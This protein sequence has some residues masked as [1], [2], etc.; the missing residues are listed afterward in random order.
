MPIWSDVRSALGGAVAQGAR[1][2][3]QRFEKAPAVSIAGI[4]GLRP[5][6]EPVQEERPAKVP[7]PRALFTDPFQISQAFGYRNRVSCL[8]YN[9]LRDLVYQ[10]PLVATIVSVRVEQVASFGHVAADKYQLGFR[11][12]MREKHDSPSS[13]EEEMCRKYEKFLLHTGLVRNDKRK[14]TFETYLR[15]IVRDALV[16]D[17]NCTELIPGNNGAPSEFYAIDASNVRLAS[18]LKDAQRPD[19]DGVAY[20]E[21]YNETIRTRWRED[22]IIFGVRN[23]NT[24][25]RLNGYGTSELEYVISSVTQMINAIKYNSAAFTNGTMARGI[26]NIRDEDLSNAQLNQIERNWNAMLK[27]VENAW[28]TPVIA[29]KNGVDWVNLQGAS[30]MQYREWLDWLVKCITASYKIA[31][32]ELNLSYGNIGQNST[33][34][35]ASNKDKI[36]DSKERGLRPL[37]RHISGNVNKHLLWP[38]APELEF[39]FCGLDAMTKE[40]QADFNNKR[41]S[42]YLTLNEIR[43]EED[44]EPL[45]GGDI[46][47]NGAYLQSLQQQ[48]MQAQ[49]AQTQ[50]VDFSDPAGG[51]EPQQDEQPQDGSQAPAPMGINDLLSMTK[52][53]SAKK[54]SSTGLDIR[55]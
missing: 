5:I 27:G 19:N 47:L 49:Q 48:Q 28:R 31:P 38:H 2:V 16:F 20:V 30:D 11:V 39:E 26:L 1:R 12:K 9:T 24:D 52:S 23:P 32:E 29:A 36:T 46:V 35:E 51:V 33:L 15:K 54:L 7:D 13:T 41:V 3:A 34:A 6:P 17:Q 8:S 4:P 21:V 25:I 37:L 40:E 44:L 14:D 43:A 42:S 10:L 53:K 55:L 18:G 45:P 50:P 22:E